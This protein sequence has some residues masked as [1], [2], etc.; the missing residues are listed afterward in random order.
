MVTYFLIFLLSFLN[1]EVTHW[2]FRYNSTSIGLEILEIFISLLRTYLYGICFKN[3]PI[4]Y[5][6]S[7][8]FRAFRKNEPWSFK[9]LITLYLHINKFWFKRTTGHFHVDDIVYWTFACIQCMLHR[10]ITKLLQRKRDNN[11][12]LVHQSYYTQ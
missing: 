4:W 7:R 5:E 2:L 6:F 12:K 11:P 9:L 10:I 3:R 8:I 1:V